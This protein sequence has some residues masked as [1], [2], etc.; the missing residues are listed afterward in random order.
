MLLPKCIKR[1]L[2]LSQSRN[3]PGTKIC[4]NY[5]DSNKLKCYQF[6]QSYTCTIN[7]NNVYTVL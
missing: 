2:M 1:N 3:Q 7:V 4:A 6:A 5:N